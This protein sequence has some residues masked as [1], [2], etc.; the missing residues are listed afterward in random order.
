MKLEADEFA[1]IVSKAVTVA[2]NQNQFDG[3]VCFCYNVGAG[4]FQESTLLKKLNAQDYTG[5]AEQF[6]VWN[7]GTINGR[8]VVLEGLTNRR[9]G[10]Q[11]T[12]NRSTDVTG[13]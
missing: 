9:K 10:Q 11:P 4:A 5:A 8:K 12:V 2:L 7:K 3:L 6:L 13:A 1:E